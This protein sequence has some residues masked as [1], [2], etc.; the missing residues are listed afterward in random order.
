MKL[1]QHLYIL[2]IFTA[3]TACNNSTKTSE[4]QDET[5]ENHSE[6]EHSSEDKN[7]LKLNGNEKW[8]ANPETTEGIN[9][10]IAL[11]DN[12]NANDQQNFAELESNL[13]TEFKL[14][15]ERCTMTG[16][17]HD[18]LHNYLIPLKSQLENSSEQ[19]VSEI[20]SYLNTY[21]DYFQ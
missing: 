18:Q 21:F 6:H 20:R 2:A 14:I 16:E 3:L 5:I 8:Q 11:I 10:M 12:F 9:N 17:A 15:F 4:K 1:K 7:K 19:N 13:H